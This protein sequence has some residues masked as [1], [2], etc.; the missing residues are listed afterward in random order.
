VAFPYRVEMTEDQRAELRGLVGAGLAP[1]RSLTRARILL[2]ADHGEG[3]PGWSDA[4]IA[5]ALDVDDSTVLRVRRRFVGTGLADTVTGKPPD[6]DDPRRLDGRREAQLVALACAVP[7][8]GAARWSLRL[9]ADEAVRL[10]IVPAISHETVRRALKR[11]DLKPRLSEQWCLAPTADPA[12]VRHMEDVLDVYE[13]PLDPARPVVCL[14]ETSRQLLANARPPA[15]SVP[16][17]PARH[18]PEYVRGGVADLFVVTEPL[19]GWRHVLVSDQRT[20]LDVAR[21]VRELLDVHDPHAERVVLVMDQLNTYSPAS[22]YAA[23]PPAEAKRRAARLEIHHPPKH[24]SRLT[25]AEIE[26]SVLERQC[27]RRRIG[28]RVALGREV[29]AWAAR[30][31]AATCRVDWHFTTADA[32]TKLTRLYPAFEA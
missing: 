16:G 25:M 11:S 22:P 19:R 9:L 13:R 24:G 8:D 29:A 30:R 14:D 32:R 28:D 26:L 10:E 15:A 23:F 31:N 27:L 17:R 4:A 1:A 3:G 20:R 18:D 21:C 7:P 6:R 5:G 12:F 2:E